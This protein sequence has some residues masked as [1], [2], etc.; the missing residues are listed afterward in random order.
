MNVQTPPADAGEPAGG[1]AGPTTGSTAA[2]RVLSWGRYPQVTHRYVHKPA[3][4]DQV[5]EILGAAGTGCLLPFGAGRSYGDSCL[6]A[7][8]DLIDCH[9]LD[10]I[11]GFEE[12]TGVVRCESGVSL[13]D[14][15]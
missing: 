14:I 13:A 7:G 1:S 4:D 3:W 5:P 12:S 15:I 10:R 11:L 2:E 9:R 6:N 8:R